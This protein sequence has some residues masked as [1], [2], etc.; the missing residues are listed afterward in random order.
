MWNRHVKLSTISS[1]KHGSTVRAL[2]TFQNMEE[3]Y[4]MQSSTFVYTIWDFIHTLYL[5]KYRCF[6]WTCKYLKSITWFTD[7]RSNDIGPNDK[8]ANNKGSKDKGSKVRQRVK[9]Q[10]VKMIKMFF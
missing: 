4:K 10:K 8:G 7:K 1:K 3:D 5:L 9:G 6:F 2:S